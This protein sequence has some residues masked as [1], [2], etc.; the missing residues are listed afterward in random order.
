L[1][2]T[3]LP[4]HLPIVVDSDSCLKESSSICGINRSCNHWSWK[5]RHHKLNNSDCWPG[6]PT[7]YRI[8]V[9]IERVTCCGRA[10]REHLSFRVCAHV[11]DPSCSSATP[12]RGRLHTATAVRRA[13]RPVPEVMHAPGLS[14]LRAP[15]WSTHPEVR[16][17]RSHTRWG[18]VA[19]VWRTLRVVRYLCP[20]ALAHAHRAPWLGV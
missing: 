10:V 16:A 2:D 12:S 8:G 15:G 1:S 17:V 7:G 13:R 4:D 5:R 3:I 18:R 9:K 19:A 20:L 11:E 6:Y 14:S